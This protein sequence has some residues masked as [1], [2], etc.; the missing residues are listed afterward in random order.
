M[1]TIPSTPRAS[2]AFDWAIMR[3]VVA[4]I[5]PASTGTWPALAPMIVSSTTSRWPSVRNGVS[6]VVPRANR[7]VTPFRSR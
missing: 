4:S 5:T 1:A 6:L 2:A 7:P 3:G